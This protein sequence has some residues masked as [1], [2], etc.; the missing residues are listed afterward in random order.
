[1]MQVDQSI[2]SYDWIIPISS[3]QGIIRQLQFL[4]KSVESEKGARS[5]VVEW[6]KDEV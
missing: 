6:R 4:R 3:V 5:S 2:E 1:M